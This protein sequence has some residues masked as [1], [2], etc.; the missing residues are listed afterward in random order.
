M[1]Y[2]RRP[3]TLSRIARCIMVVKTIV[4]FTIQYITSGSRNKC[5]LDEVFYLSISRTTLWVPYSEW[6][7]TALQSITIRT[8]RVLMRVFM[9]LKTMLDVTV[10]NGVI[11]STLPTTGLIPSLCIFV[12]SLSFIKSWSKIV[13]RAVLNQSALR[14]HVPTHKNALTDFEKSWSSVNAE[15]F[16]RWWKKQ[17]DFCQRESKLQRRVFFRDKW[18]NF[19][20]LAFLF[21]LSRLQSS[22]PMMPCNLLVLGMF[23]TAG[24]Q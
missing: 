15:F 20:L 1:P 7:P 19:Y 5:S 14:N 21:L 12:L 18:L 22:P 2:P 3:D 16:N 10:S 9:L 23:C 4:T 24:V 11:Y 6:C 13:R 17:D 8:T